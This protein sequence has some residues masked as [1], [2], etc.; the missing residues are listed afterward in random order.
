[1]DAAGNPVFLESS[2]ASNPSQNEVILSST[3]ESDFCPAAR[4]LSTV[5]IP[6]VPRVLQFNHNIP[7]V[8]RLS[9]SESISSSIGDSLNPDVPEFIPNELTDKNNEPIGSNSRNEQVKTEIQPEEVKIIPTPSNKGSSLLS[10]N[11]FSE[12]DDK[13]STTAKCSSSSPVPKVQ[14]NGESQSANDVWKE[15]IS[16][17]CIISI[18][19]KLN[20]RVFLIHRK[21]TLP[22]LQVI[23]DLKLNCTFLPRNVKN[24]MNL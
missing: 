15:V 2:D 7:T 3:S 16:F 14:I 21:N 18:N 17:S 12:V 23:Q 22:L 20:V 13:L 4:P 24:T 9:E 8:G 6:P 1:M 19:I 5:P 10:R 11:K